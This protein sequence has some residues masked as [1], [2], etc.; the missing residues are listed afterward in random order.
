MTQ[1]SEQGPYHSGT[2]LL[3]WLTGPET[4]FSGQWG[5]KTLR[6]E[7]SPAGKSGLVLVPHSR[8]TLLPKA[9]SKPGIAQPRQGKPGAR[10]AAGPRILGGGHQGTSVWPPRPDSNLLPVS[11]SP[12]GEEEA[13]ILMA[14]KHLFPIRHCQALMSFGTS[15]EGQFLLL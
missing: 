15:F 4:C 8:R 13:A 5:K 6:A 2:E 1:E 14:Q 11:W 3:S 12:R 7:P 9:V 10:G